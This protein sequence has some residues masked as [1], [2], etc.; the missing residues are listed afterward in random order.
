MIEAANALALE[1]PSADRTN[2][3]GEC[4]ESGLRILAYI[5]QGMTPEKVRELIGKPIEISV[6]GTYWRVWRAQ[7]YTRG[8]LFSN[9]C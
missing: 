4:V 9:T 6:S 2:Q 3:V 7:R 5:E 1:P 8:S